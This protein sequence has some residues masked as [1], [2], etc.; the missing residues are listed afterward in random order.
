MRI[1]HTADWHLTERL[2][3]I[4]RQ[5]DLEDRLNEIARYLEEYDVDVMVVAGDMFSQCTRWE[6]VEKG[7]KAVNA[8]FKKYLLR[9]G[10]IVAI[11]GN[12]D[13]E[14]LFSI[15]HTMLDLGAPIDTF[16]QHDEPRPVGRLYIGSGPGI[17]RLQDKA[18]VI[19][20]FVLLPY[21]TQARYLKD[22]KTS[23]SSL[24]EKHR[25]LHDE[26]LKRLK[27]IQEQWLKVD[28]RSV[29]VAHVHVRGSE[30]NS[31]YHL[32]ESDDIIYER[33]EIPAHW[34]YIAYGHIHK[35]QSVKGIPH[36]HYAGSIERLDCNEQEDKSVVL[37][38]IGPDGRQG[39]PRCLRLDATPFYQEEIRNP[40][41]EI[42]KLRARYLDAQRALVKCR[43]VYKPGEDLSRFVREIRAIFP[44]CYDI[45]PEIEGSTP[46]EHT[47][48]QAPQARSVEE[49]VESYINENL[50][51]SPLREDVLTLARELLATID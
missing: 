46:V 16:Q 48:Q 14:Q 37:V 51:K 19:V 23:Y 40:E 25:N 13:N 18:G 20:Q 32:S 30:I 2:R 6:E 41:T 50:K 3:G 27:T 35:P 12:H 7:V 24:G 21:P 9:G 36:A 15:L 45:Q 31:P 47:M 17:L 8:I 22:E 39:D 38:D 11:S 42:P 26:L 34:D 10:T 1:L 29:L 5:P 33:G 4:D 43:L 44:R 28:Q 49:I